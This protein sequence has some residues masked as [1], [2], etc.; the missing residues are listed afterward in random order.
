MH[1]DFTQRKLSKLSSNARPVRLLFLDTETKVR[2]AK[3]GQDREVVLYGYQELFY[4]ANLKDIEL[5]RFKLGWTCFSRYNTGKGFV[6]DK[7]LLWHNSKD[8]CKYIDSLA[9]DKTTLYFFGHHI[10]FDLQVSDFFYYFTKWGW[11]LEFLYDKGLTYI[12]VIR[13]GSRTIKCLS[14]TNYFPIS[15]EKLGSSLGIPKLDINFHS[16]LQSDLVRYCK[17]DTFI[18]RKAIEY[19]IKFIDN[20]DLGKFCLGRPAQALTAYR[21]RFM[22]KPI[23]IHKN[24]IV[25]ELEM[26]GYLGGRVE[27][28]FLGKLPKDNYISLDINSMYPYVMKKYKMPVKLIDYIEHLSIDDLP[29]L[30]DKFAVVAEVL[31]NTNEPAYGIR[32]KGK[33]VFPTGSFTTVLCSEGLRYAYRHKHLFAIKQAAIYQ[34]EYIFNSYVNY[35]MKLK[36]KYSKEGN[37]FLREVSKYFLLYLYGKFAQ[38]KD[39]LL[40]QEDITFDGYFREETYDLVTA[41]T[42]IITK[43]FNKK[44]I[45]FE[46]EPAGCCFL[47]IPAHVTEYAR[48]HLYKLMKRVGLNKVLYC[49]TDSIKL[50]EKD[51]QP[52][53][54]SIHPDKLGKLKVEE[55]FTKFIINGA[56]NYQTDN[57]KKIKGVP[58]KA[59]QIADYTYSYMQFMKQATHLR[60]E[61]TRYFIVKPEIKV[62]KP[63]YDKGK[64]LSDGRII[65]YELNQS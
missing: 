36:E 13:K 9:P 63:Y 2:T 15:L 10:F 59:Q 1:Q 55:R 39:V 47:P 64:V 41:K 52:L 7:W 8:L 18:I 35:F 60:A 34:K 38:Q 50:R 21:Y 5:H 24:K 48:F 30:L 6:S 11:V 31:L 42:E 37:A 46:R 22:D 56:K 57:T 12:L 53:T 26:K 23:Y 45:T 61:V 32:Y 51:M 33:L 16:C 40:E 19:F 43:L 3:F 17:R 14:T 65:P 28:G 62:V 58:S 49:D 44:W 27:C 29:F 54:K 20:H 25:Q 4:G